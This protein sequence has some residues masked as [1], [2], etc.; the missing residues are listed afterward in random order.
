MSNMTGTDVTIWWVR[1]GPTHAK[2]FVGWSDLA[3]DLSD[4]EA[5]S[6]LSRSL[7]TEATVVSSDLARAVTTAD[8][9][10]G[11][12]PRLPHQPKLR[13]MNFGAWELRTFTDIEADDPERAKAF[14]TTP[15][16]IRPP[17]GE[18]WNMFSDR[19][20]AAVDG[21]LAQG[22]H[23]LVAVAH[24]GVIVSQIQRALSLDPDA[25]FAHR[26]DPL[27][28]TTVRYGRL[29]MADPINHKP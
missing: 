1:H 21:L 2:S 27:S 19:V 9:I 5:V 4:H 18:S 6:R 12:R 23:R 24:F 11:D 10:A 7:P 15:G 26:I 16:D 20:N 29:P 28:V 8:A 25:A 13:E 3:A 22:A 17:G 14:W